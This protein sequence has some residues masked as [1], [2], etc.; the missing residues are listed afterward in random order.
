V[1]DVVADNVL[2]SSMWLASVAAC[3]QHQA[4]LLPVALVFTSIEWVTF[5]STQLTAMADAGRYW[6]RCRQRDPAFVLH[7]FRDDFRCGGPFTFFT[8]PIMDELSFCYWSSD[9]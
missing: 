1:L 6:K 4:I 2:R 5:F 3:P 7:Y 9:S 8:A